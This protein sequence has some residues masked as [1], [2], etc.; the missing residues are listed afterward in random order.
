MSRGAAD[1]H[2]LTGLVRPGPAPGPP[3]ALLVPLGDPGHGCPRLPDGRGPDQQ[4]PTPTIPDLIGLTCNETPYLF[5][6]LLARPAADRAHRLRWSVWR[7][8]QQA[9]ARA[10]HYRQQANGHEGHDLRLEY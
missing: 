9:R 1:Q 6:A 2:T 7:R 5:A 8:R 10:C 4:H 3:L